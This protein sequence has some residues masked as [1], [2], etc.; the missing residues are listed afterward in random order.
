MS[1]VDWP[2]TGRFAERVAVTYESQVEPLKRNFETDNIKTAPTF[3]R[4]GLYRGFSVIAS[5]LCT[6]PSC[7]APPDGWEFVSSGD[8]RDRFRRTMLRQPVYTVD[9]GPLG[10]PFRVSLVQR[11]P[12]RLGQMPSDRVSHQYL[13]P[14]PGTAISPLACCRSELPMPS[15]RIRPLAALHSSTNR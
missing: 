1:K 13:S 5:I 10:E 9:S 2:L 6:R 14:A 4:I 15:I 12:A 7:P 11:N 3:R 8:I